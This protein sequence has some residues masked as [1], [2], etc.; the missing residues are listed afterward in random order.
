MKKVFWVLLK[1]LKAS[2]PSNHPT[3]GIWAMWNTQYAKI[4]IV[5]DMGAPLGPTLNLQA[6]PT[7]SSGDLP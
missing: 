6:G 5:K 2:S 3:N 4:C 1:H 7:L